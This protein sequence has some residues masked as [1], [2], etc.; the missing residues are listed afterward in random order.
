MK[1][2]ILLSVLI[3]I[4]INA[5]SQLLKKLKEK[6]VTK[7]EQKADA[8]IDRKID[9]AIDSV[10]EGNINLPKKEHQVKK[11]TIIKIKES[12]KNTIAVKNEVQSSYLSKFDFIPGDEIVFFEDFSDDA[13]GDFPAKWNTTG[14]GEVVTID[15]V[16]GN[17]LLLKSQQ[18]S[19][20]L[21]DLINLPENFT[22]QF[23]VMLSLP[24]AWRNEPI[25]FAMADVKNASNYINTTHYSLNGNNNKAFWLNLH[26]GNADSNSYGGYLMYNTSTTNLVNE[27][28]D[29]KKSFMVIGEKLPLKVSIWKQ[30]QRIRVYLN[31]NKVL[32]LP[33]ILP[34][35]MNVNALVWSTL[36]LQENN[37]YFIGNIRVA[38]S[39]PDSR[40][41]LITEGKLVSNGIL[42][43]IN[44]DKIKP[45]SYGVIKEIAGVLK[46]N[47]NVT[48]TIVG[49]TDSDGDETSN[50]ELSQ[51]RALA[52]KN[53]LT[54]EFGVDALRMQT[55]GKGES[56]PVL[57]NTSMINKA[58]NRRVEFI[59]TN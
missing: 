43:G 48:I 40:N 14:S 37:N 27:K 1:K 26:H 23:D 12:K 3:L 18:T 5:N 7:T 39:N 20:S 38:S 52:I 8:K 42:F 17:W 10:M 15:G 31:E 29:L 36:S 11:D 51:K 4:A 50:L 21:N 47:K 28:L 9:V 13:I 22:V 56:E 19:F 41:K 58:N 6:V 57:P 30:K 54:Q 49:H 24:F 34:V 16:E 2:K 44:S 35:E 59:K 45:E 55:D 25:Y 33:K 53:M 32:D 46:E